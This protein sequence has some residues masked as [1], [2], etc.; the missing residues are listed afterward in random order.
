MRSPRYRFSG[1]C[2]RFGQM[3]VSAAASEVP[4]AGRTDNNQATQLLTSSVVRYQHGVC[5]L[6][7]CNGRIRAKEL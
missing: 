7:G 2:C 3:A 6:K 5:V 1:Y 4:I